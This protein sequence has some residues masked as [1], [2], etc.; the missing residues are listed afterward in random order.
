MIF[1]RRRLS[2]G[3]ASTFDGQMAPG[4]APATIRQMR[5]YLHFRDQ[6]PALGV[7]GVPWLLLEPH[8]LHMNGRR[9][10]KCGGNSLLGRILGPISGPE[11][12][13]LS[14]SCAKSLMIY[15]FLAFRVP[16]HAMLQF[17]PV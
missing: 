8:R 9:A 1:A 17:M 15:T 7:S 13:T 6:G 16:L 2:S 14:I 4:L 3:V 12:R 10:N 11:A 5:C